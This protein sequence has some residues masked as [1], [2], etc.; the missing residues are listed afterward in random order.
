[1]R[2][3]KSSSKNF[4][5]FWSFHAKR[6]K[7]RN[8]AKP[9]RHAGLPR[10]SRSCCGHL[11]VWRRTSARFRVFEFGAQGTQVRVEKKVG[12]G[13]RVLGLGFRVGLFLRFWGLRLGSQPGEPRAVLQAL[14]LEPYAPKP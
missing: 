13:F 4:T 14:N 8:P 5:V 11:H 12:L 10:L 7:N 1:M 3:F 2:S 9:E 6:S